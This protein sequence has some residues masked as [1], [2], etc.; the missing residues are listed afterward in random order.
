[1][2]IVGRYIDPNGNIIES[3]KTN[4]CPQC[5]TTGPGLNNSDASDSILTS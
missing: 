2:E 3:N 5:D 4:S 1:M